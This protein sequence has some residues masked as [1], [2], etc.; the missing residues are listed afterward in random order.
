MYCKYV[1]I[2]FCMIWLNNRHFQLF[3]IKC[4][5]D[6]NFRCVQQTPFAISTVVSYTRLIFNPTEFGKIVTRIRPA[7]EITYLKLHF[8]S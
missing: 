4:M 8:Y 7:A 2:R 3:Y 1:C 5:T 6:K